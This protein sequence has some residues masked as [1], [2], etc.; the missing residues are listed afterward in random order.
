MLRPT[1]SS[2]KPRQ[3]ELLAYSPGTR[4]LDCLKPLPCDQKFLPSIFGFLPGTRKFMSAGLK[5]LPSTLKFVPPGVKLLLSVVNLS[6]AGP[7]GLFQHVEPFSRNAKLFLS[8][9]EHFRMLCDRLRLSCE[10]N[11]PHSSPPP[12]FIPAGFR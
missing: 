9:L 8:S 6:V 4:L 7:Q 2:S 1:E 5:L 12:L 11:Q 3:R 10:Q